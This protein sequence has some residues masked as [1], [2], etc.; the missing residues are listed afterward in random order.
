MK[1]F[2][3]FVLVFVLMVMITTV[4]FAGVLDKAKDFLGSSAV[5]GTITL[6]FVILSGVLGGGLLRFKRPVIMMYDVYCEYRDAKLKDS[7]GGEK[8]TQEEWD[9]IFKKIGE[10]VMAL[11]AV[12]PGSWAKNLKIG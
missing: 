9:N 12:A 11:L 8:V 3:L 7:E 10:A 5:H 6:L 4:A 2:L 1:K